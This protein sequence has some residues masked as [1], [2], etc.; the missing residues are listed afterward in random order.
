MM[1][2]FL[3]II[4]WLLAIPCAAMAGG[5]PQANLGAAAST[6]TLCS[7]A[8]AVVEA[9]AFATSAEFLF[10]FDA[11]SLPANGTVGASAK[12]VAA[13]P[14]NG[15]GSVTYTAAEPGIFLSGVVLGCSSTAPPTFTAA[16][17]CEFF[18][19]RAN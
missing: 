5:Q 10:V 15:V 17:S 3:C 7:T 12:A 18:F 13:I 11:T 19:G 8:C 1:R 4:L 2:K 16:S 9:N 14:A 6:F